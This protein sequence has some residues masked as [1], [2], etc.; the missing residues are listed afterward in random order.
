MSMDISIWSVSPPPMPPDLAGHGHWEKY[1]DAE[2]D[3]YELDCDDWMLEVSTSVNSP[4][5]DVL[6]HLPDAKWETC[7]SLSPT[8]ASADAYRSLEEVV[9]NLCKACGGCWQHPGDGR[10]YRHDEGVF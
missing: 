2:V 4:A 6:A 9:R 8:G 3:A 5:A 1:P 10:F 7:V